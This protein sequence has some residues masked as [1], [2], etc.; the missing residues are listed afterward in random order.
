MQAREIHRSPG[1]ALFSLIDGIHE[2]QEAFSS[3]FRPLVHACILQHLG[4]DLSGLLEQNVQRIVRRKGVLLFEPVHPVR[5]LGLD[6]V[7]PQI[8]P[9]DDLLPP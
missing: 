7:G 1:T 6:R 9:G 5:V 4:K 2:F 3:V 8:R